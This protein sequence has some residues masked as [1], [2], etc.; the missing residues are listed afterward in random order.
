MLTLAFLSHHSKHLIVKLVEEITSYNLNLKIIVIEN[1]LDF[2]LKNK[3]EKKYKDL[4]NIY[5]PEE[6]LGFSKGMNKAIEL[7]TDQFVFL[8]PADVI[9]PYQCLS[10]LLVCIKNFQDF[11]LLAP[12]YKDEKIFKNYETSIFSKNEKP[13]KFKVNKKFNLHEVDWID[14]TFIVNKKQ[15]NENKIMDENMFIY[16]ETMDMCLNFK[17]QNKKMYIIDNIKFEHLGGRS[18]EKKFNFEASL[19]R[20]WHYNWSKFYYYKKN[21]GYFYA[22]KKFITIILKNFSK[23]IFF[24]IKRENN[25]YLLKKAE[26]KGSLA[27]IFFKKSNYRPY[28]NRPYKK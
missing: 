22:L 20:N 13:N 12:T 6:N 14:G 1:S 3:L 9:L 16:F 15:I 10:D 7:S 21:F 4:V 26:I 18:H 8:N 23:L 2:E 5:I 27:S 25:N 19:S 11:T 24:I 17:K 28:K